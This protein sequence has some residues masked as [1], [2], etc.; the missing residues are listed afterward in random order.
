MEIIIIEIVFIFL[1]FFLEILKEK[2]DYVYMEIITHPKLDNKLHIFGDSL[3]MIG[4]SVTGAGIY[5]YILK[6]NFLFFVL[7]Y[8]IMFILIGA[9]IRS[10]Y[11]KEK[12]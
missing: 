6:E 8:G 10:H 2:I 12:K 4:G 11:Q 3:Y 7:S 5:E 1:L 9:S